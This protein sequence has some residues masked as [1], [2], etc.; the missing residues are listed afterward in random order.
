MTDPNSEHAVDDPTAVDLWGHVIKGFQATNR[1]I[2]GAIK[3]AYNLNEAE[4]ETL[5]TLQR[6][7]EHR[8]PMATLARATAFSS[9]GF[10]KIA[11]KLTNR[12][13]TVR[14]A[15]ADDR[16]VIYLQL[17]TEGAALT[18]EL[19]C[20]VADINRAYFI[21]V[22]GPDRARLIAEAMRDLHAFN[23]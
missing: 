16:R 6:H 11:D 17:S 23:E 14:A 4:T 20:L 5:L 7:A 9:G 18:A 3:D 8:A 13:L 12:G 19:A 1:R 21:E 22:L 2:H 15:C 10:T